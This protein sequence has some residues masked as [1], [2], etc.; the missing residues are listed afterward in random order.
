MRASGLIA[1]RKLLAL[2]RPGFGA[3]LVETDRENRGLEMTF[4]ELREMQILRRTP[5]GIRMTA[6]LVVATSCIRSALPIEYHVEPIPHVIGCASEPCAPRDETKVTYLGVGGFLIESRGRVLLTGPSFTNPSLDSVTPTRYRFFRGRAPTI[7]PDNP[8]IDRLLPPAADKASMILV[9]H[10][11][12]DHLLDVPHVANTRARDAEIYGG[13]TVRHMLLGDS[14]LRA[15]ASRVIAI[16]GADVGRV[17]RVGRW[18]TSKD[19]AFRIMALEADHART[20]NLFARWGVLFAAGS[21]DRDLTELPPFQ[22]DVDSEIAGR[23]LFQKPLETTRLTNPA[24]SEV[25]V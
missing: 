17:D 8:L 7:R 11:H 23:T 10:G 15:H 12:Y 9:G 3:S 4:R 22:R 1:T 16:S 18:F 5:C 24:V 14:A 19:R 6:V 25:S 2:S 21:L 20:V 13:P